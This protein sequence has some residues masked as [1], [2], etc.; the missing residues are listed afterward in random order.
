M[1]KQRFTLIELLF[2]IA[3]IAILAAMLLPALSAA[4][5]RARA[6][7]CV[8]NL[9]MVGTGMLMYNN[10]NEYYPD[11]VGLVIMVPFRYYTLV[12]GGAT[13]G[14]LA[15]YLRPY[16]DTDIAP[17]QYTKVSQRYNEMWRCPGNTVPDTETNPAY[18]I[19]N[20]RQINSTVDSVIWR[21]PFGQGGVKPWSVSELEKNLPPASCWLMEDIDKYNVSWQAPQNTW[22]PAHNQGR[23][24]LY[25]DGHVDWVKATSNY[26]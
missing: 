19:A 1:K 21:G 16:L 26:P 23:N 4:R 5:A 2:V 22:Q 11:N 17:N 8:S 13:T 18:Y 10:D 7:T 20:N 25:A 15:V 9:K 6:A 24:V 12:G 14:N 3:I